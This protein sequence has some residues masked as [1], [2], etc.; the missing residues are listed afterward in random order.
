MLLLIPFHTARV[1]NWEEDFYMFGMKPRKK[2]SAGTATLPALEHTPPRGGRHVVVDAR[3]HP[4]E[5]SRED[6]QQEGWWFER[7]CIATI[8]LIIFVTVVL[9]MLIW[10]AAIVF[11]GSRM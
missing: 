6:Q 8:V 11:A 5:G 1:F 2:R 7:G 4:G 10:A 9:P 3:A